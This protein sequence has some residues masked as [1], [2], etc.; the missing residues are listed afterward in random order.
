M[1]GAEYVTSDGRKQSLPRFYKDKIFNRGMLEKELRREMRL[2]DAA[3][4]HNR[5][6]ERLRSLHPD[7]FNYM[8]ERERVAHDSVRK[9]G[10]HLNKF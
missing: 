3:D 9:K 10:N 7:P 4:R 8:V 5:E 2:N 1:S 6:L